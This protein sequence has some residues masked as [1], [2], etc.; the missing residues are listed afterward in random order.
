MQLRQ[1]QTS[2]RNPPDTGTDTFLEEPPG[3]QALGQAFEAAKGI[4]IKTGC[5]RR[6]QGAR[7]LV[8]LNH[9]VE[10]LDKIGGLVVH[11]TINPGSMHCRT[12]SSSFGG[13]QTNDWD[14]EDIRTDLSP[15]P[16][17]AASSGQANLGRLDP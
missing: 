2:A 3:G 12:K 10:E 13:R 16:A 6:R 17:L 5:R 15:D 4:L 11:E 1:N 14:S 8:E 9:C 7:R